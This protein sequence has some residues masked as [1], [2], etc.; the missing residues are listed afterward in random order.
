MLLGTNI[1]K[2]RTHTSPDATARKIVNQDT[3]AGLLSSEIPKLKIW[4]QM[5][6]KIEVKSA[7]RSKKLNLFDEVE[8]KLFKFTSDAQKDRCA[9]FI[10]AHLTAWRK[11]LLRNGGKEYLEQGQ[12]SCRN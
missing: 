4:H 7:D 1:S 6:Q 10:S 9:E 11:S 8:E 5:R 12:Y 3:S 2:I